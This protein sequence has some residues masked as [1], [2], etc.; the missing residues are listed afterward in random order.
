MR[1]TLLVLFLLLT[2]TIHA[3][4]TLGI[5]IDSTTRIAVPGVRV[6]SNHSR[7][8]SDGAGRFSISTT[9]GDTLTFEL[10]NYQSYKYKVGAQ[11]TAIILLKRSP[12]QLHEV[13]VNGKRTRIQDSLDNRQQFA[14]VFNYTPPK[15]TDAFGMPSGAPVPFAFFSVNLLTLVQALTKNS[16]PTYKLKKL[17]LKDE[18]A[19]YIHSR[20]NR[21]LVSGLTHLKGDSLQ[22]FMDKYTPTLPWLQKA[23][24]YE[25]IEYVKKNYTEFQA[26]KRN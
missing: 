6:Y 5:V 1:Y 24:D 17:M 7:T 15:V 20:F 25:L 12:T 18:Q 4:T 21:G 9:T 10:K 13:V 26:P 14:S 19:D 16:D 2:I 11:P 22:T 3:Q 23:S 8:I